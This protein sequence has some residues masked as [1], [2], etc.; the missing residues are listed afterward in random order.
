MFFKVRGAD[1]R[2]ALDCCRVCK[3]AGQCSDETERAEA[4]D[5]F[6]FG[7]YAGETPA[8]RISR[9]AS[10]ALPDTA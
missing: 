5:G 9:R 8:M 6:A 3:V 7:I 2:K 4:I 1:M 10:A